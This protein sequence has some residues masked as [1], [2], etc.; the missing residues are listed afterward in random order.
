MNLRYRV[1]HLLHNDDH[2]SLSNYYV[3]YFLAFLI[4][5]NVVAVI[6][7]SIPGVYADYPLFFDAFENISIAIFSVEYLLRLWSIAEQDK[8]VSA[9]RLRVKWLVSG[10]AIIDLMAILPAYLNML[11][12]FDLRILRVLRLIRLLKLARYFSSLQILLSVIKK[13]KG[14]FQAVILILLVLIIIAASGIY[15][16]ENKAQPEVF[17]SIPKAMWWAVVT[18]TTVGYGDIT[19]I[20]GLGKFLGALITILGVGIA[21]LPAGILASGLASELSHRDQERE[22]AF[23]KLLHNHGYKV[24]QDKNELEKL[25]RHIPLTR[26]QAHKVITQFIRE[27]GAEQKKQPMYYC[28]HCGGKLEDRSEV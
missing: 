4:I 13:E 7:E 28:P 12:H 1:F 8:A 14:S 20:T 18:L 24:I 3:G 15:V 21:A 25:W 10:G 9:W 23:F 27:L 19:P 16:V 26:S 2:D 22:E 6:L 17:S 5:G 11:V